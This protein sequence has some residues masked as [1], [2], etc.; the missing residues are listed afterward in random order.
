MALENVSV[1]SLRSAIT[2]CKDA[3]NYSNDVQVLNSISNTAIWKCDSSS[4]LK[5]AINKLIN[6]RYKKLEEKLDSYSKIV[7][8]IEEYQELHSENQS[9]ELK[10]SE[11]DRKISSNKYIMNDD[12]RERLEREERIMQNEIYSLHKKISNNVDQMNTIKSKISDLI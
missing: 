9:F 11:L 4:T 6:K 5:T 7:S 10:Q 2:S 3:I 12:N 8:Y 1:S